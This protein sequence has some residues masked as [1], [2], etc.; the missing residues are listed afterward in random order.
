MQWDAHSLNAVILYAALAIGVPLLLYFLLSRR[1]RIISPDSNAAR[2]FRPTFF[3][4]RHKKALYAFADSRGLSIQPE[5][6]DGS[7]ARRF[8][9]QM[10]LP[11]HGD[12]E[13]IMKVPLPQGEGY[14]FTQSP[15]V[16]DSDSTS[17]GTPRHSLVVFSPLPLSGRTFLTPKFPLGGSVGRK[18]IEMLL[19]HLFGV[20]D[21]S[22]VE[23]EREFPEFSKKV[24]V[25]SEDED[26]A[27][28]V[29]LNE[30]I[31]SLLLELQGKT[32]INMAV[33]PGGLAIHIEP[34][35]KKVEQ[36]EALVGWSEKIIRALSER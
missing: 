36:I 3:T 24:T 1:S 26:G 27:R 22:F 12:I 30:E 29:L 17:E 2:S 34:M 32:I 35:I 19:S 31:T 28:G 16:T 15:D 20:R 11:V 9:E 23:T 7:L 14:F 5:D 8:V 4:P 25:F 18:M 13:D 10:N 33:T 6:T 21:V